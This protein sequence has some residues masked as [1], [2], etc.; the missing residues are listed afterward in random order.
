MNFGHQDRWNSRLALLVNYYAVCLSCSSIWKCSSLVRALFHRG[1]LSSEM[2]HFAAGLSTLKKER[3]VRSNQQHSPVVLYRR[4]CVC[5]RVISGLVNVNE[6]A[7]EKMSTLRR[8]EG[9]P[10]L[11]LRRPVYCMLR[12]NSEEMSP[13]HFVMSRISAGMGCRVI[14]IIFGSAYSGGGNQ[15]YT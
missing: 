4:Q 6:Q 11:S 9:V 12:Q 14:S 3:S 2:V 15:G 5:P 7:S 1:R 13:C 10:C 8:M